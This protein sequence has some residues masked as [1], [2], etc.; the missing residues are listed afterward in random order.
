MVTPIRTWSFD[1]NHSVVGAT[2]TLKYSDA[3]FRL[4]DL[5]VSVGSWAVVQSSD[6]ATSG[7]SDLWVDSGDVVPDTAGNA[8]S[9]VL[10]QAPASFVS[11]GVVA[12]LLDC[13][14]NATTPTDL[15]LTLAVDTTPSGGS[16]TAAPSLTNSQLH[17]NTTFWGNNNN[18]RHTHAAITSV[19]DFWFGL[20]EDGTDKLDS[21]IV[22]L[23]CDNGEAAN[24]YPAALYYARPA[25][26][27]GAFD[28][29]ALGDKTRWAGFGPSGALVDGLVLIVTGATAAQ[30][31]INGLSNAT[32]PRTV[33]TPID[34]YIDSGTQGTYVGRVA[35]L[36]GA[37]STLP[38]NTSYSGDAGAQRYL[39]INGLWV[40]VP[41]GTTLVL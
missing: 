26:P 19:G 35:D 9:W 11:G 29:D 40:V 16:T 12:L 24:A 7:A 3:V 36:R 1:L 33:D 27:Y 18:P 6:G 23:R 15:R 30:S 22:V 14:T 17:S 37:P 4:K 25:T 20:A 2:Q 13:A 31:W 28:H 8:H 38:P 5:L 39:S 34:A 41:S 32:T 10:L 21:A